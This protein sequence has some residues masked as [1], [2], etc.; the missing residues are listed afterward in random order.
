LSTVLDM[1]TSVAIGPD[2]RLYVSTIDSIH[3][4][5]VDP[6]T[7]QVIAVEDVA[8]GLGSVLAITFDPSESPVPVVLYASHQDFGATA[9]YQGVVSRFTEGVS[10]WT[11]E[12]V[13]TNLPGDAATYNHMTEGL[14]F[15]ADGRLLIAN[16]SSTDAGLDT[17]SFWPETPLSAAILEADVNDPSFDGEVT[18][19]PP[20]P[21]A[22][23]DVDQAG[24][25]VSV[26]AS[27][28]RNPYDLVVHTNGKIYSTDNGP[29][30]PSYSATCS[31]QASGVD[32]SDKLNLIVEDN[33]YGHPNR[34]RGRF[35][36]RQCT[37]F[38]ADAPSGS[39]YS[40]PIAELPSGCSCDGITEYTSNAFGGAIQGDLLIAQWS[41]GV[42]RR[43][44]LS[45]DG[46]SVA[47]MS[48]LAIDFGQS[49]DVAVTTDGTIYVAEFGADR[50]AY[51]APDHDRD[52][53]SDAREAGTDEV[54]GGERN[55][56][57][58]WDFYDTP[59]GANVRDGDVAGTDF[60]RLL[61]RFGTMGSPAGDPLSAPPPS[62]YHT[63]F[64]RGSPSGDPWDL[65][66]AN[67]SISG[68]DF[69]SM[70]GQFGHSCG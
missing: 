28:T 21:P 51:L 9:P 59:D 17:G 47:S 26:F 41:L 53:C 29:A 11:R 36:T 8:T 31:T 19:D 23:H 18:Y 33:Y 69:F 14:A 60:F 43:V 20:G 63:A 27:G 38:R 30:G 64:D 40:A 15:H 16:G 34:N 48:I 7:K 3:A 32:T 62:G 70:L 10:S 54:A 44:E 61:A 22:D 39:G 45:P 65:T 12:D 4:L 25:D 57:N 2:G 42:L 24:G 67:G 56:K 50:I 5:T 13:I 55:A 66:A 37:Y 49:L 68:T 52:G 58:F 35:D 6:A 46:N 1:P